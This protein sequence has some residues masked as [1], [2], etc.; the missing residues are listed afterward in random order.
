MA[1]KRPHGRFLFFSAPFRST[2][3]PVPG[4]SSRLSES[5]NV[6]AR[7]VEAKIS[8]RGTYLAAISQQ[9]GKRTLLSTEVSVKYKPII[10]ADGS[11]VLW[12][13]AGS[14][15]YAVSSSGGSPE[16]LC[17]R[18]GFPYDWSDDR[19]RILH[20]ARPSGSDA[21]SRMVNLETGKSHVFLEH[22]GM[23]FYETHWSPDGR[24]IATASPS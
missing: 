14:G 21:I 7:F 23:E 19:K 20:F 12:N 3:A 17:E 24:W 10:Q 16:K 18:C 11:R 2:I 1:S 9:S 13:D 5:T 8:P 4:K 15:L 22:P 6:H